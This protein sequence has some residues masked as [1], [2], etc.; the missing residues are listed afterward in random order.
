[1]VRNLTTKH[2]VTSAS[3]I[4]KFDR[5]NWKGYQHKCGVKRSEA[6]KQWDDVVAGKSKQFEKGSLSNGKLCVVLHDVESEH[7]TPK[8]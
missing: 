6:G 1:M 7:K 4:L 2:E 5:E 3:G 8:T